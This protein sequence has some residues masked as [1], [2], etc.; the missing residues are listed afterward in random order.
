MPR[1]AI[2]N[3]CHG[4]VANAGLF[5]RSSRMLVPLRFLFADAAKINLGEARVGGRRSAAW[6][7]GRGAGLRP[8]TPARNQCSG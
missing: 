3:S 5:A 1:A 7:K 2:R 4:R 8:S 6:L